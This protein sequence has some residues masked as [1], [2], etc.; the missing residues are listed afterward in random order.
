MA[1][2][3]HAACKWGTYTAARKRAMQQSGAAPVGGARR[4][5]ARALPAHR[6]VSI[7]H[8]SRVGTASARHFIWRS[9]ARGTAL[10]GISLAVDNSRGRLALQRERRTGGQRRLGS[11]QCWSL[12][13][14]PGF[15]C[16]NGGAALPAGSTI[17]LTRPA[18][19]TT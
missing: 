12:M 4:S 1:R 10:G 16:Q 19:P 13:P 11:R 6:A 8:S 7:D 15:F 18:A 2:L 9:L 5:P 17:P 3:V 14:C